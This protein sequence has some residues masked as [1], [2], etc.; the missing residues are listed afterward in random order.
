[1][2]LSACVAPPTEIKSQQAK[3]LDASVDS[4]FVE[5]HLALIEDS[6]AA[7]FKT[8]ILSELRQSSVRA[9]VETVDTVALE[10]D[11][12]QHEEKLKVFQPV[13]ILEI[14]P[15]EGA[16]DR[17]LRYIKKYFNASLLRYSPDPAQRPLLWRARI[18]LE[19]VGFYIDERDCATFARDL[20]DKLRADGV[21][22]AQ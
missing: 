7:S 14:M 1:L 11:R 21:I 5:S 6:W 16:V 12:T 17:E 13:A 9:T 22:K 10:A 2:L 15:A 3:S 19:A 18:Y 20:A 4:I 8:V